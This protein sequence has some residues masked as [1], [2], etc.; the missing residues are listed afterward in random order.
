MLVAII[1]L[2]SCSATLLLLLACSVGDCKPMKIQKSLLM[3]YLFPSLTSKSHAFFPLVCRLTSHADYQRRGARETSS[4]S[5]V[6]ARVR[7]CSLKHMQTHTHTRM[8]SEPWC[9]SVRF[10]SPLNISLPFFVPLLSPVPSRLLSLLP[11]SSISS[12]YP[13]ETGR[14]RES[15]GA[16]GRAGRGKQTGFRVQVHVQKGG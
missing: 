7:M 3:F 12:A 14:A 5:L 6:N 2:G 1:I 8:H 13:G 16:R 15:E 4:D 9:L 10:P 11:A